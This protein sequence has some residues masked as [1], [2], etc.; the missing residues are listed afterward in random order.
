YPGSGRAKRA[1]PRR[2]SRR[3]LV[4][5]LAGGP[6]VR[7]GARARRVAVRPRRRVAGPGRAGPGRAGAARAHRLVARGPCAPAHRLAH[8][9]DRDPHEG[10][11]QD[12]LEEPAGAPLAAG[13]L[14]LLRRLEGLLRALEGRLQLSG[15]RFHLLCLTTRL[16]HGRLPDLPR[17]RPFGRSCRTLL[18]PLR[19]S[20]PAPPATARRSTPTK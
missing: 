2:E 8:H 9:H 6:L 19:G 1:R 3:R 12:E 10:R 11:E 18:P 4:D 15:P 5:L 16:A 13:R 14:H 20:P 7:R 17:G